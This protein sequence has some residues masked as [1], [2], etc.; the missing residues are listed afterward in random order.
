MRLIALAACFALFSQ[1]SGAAAEAPASGESTGP[2][3][4]GGA[5]N[6]LLRSESIGQTFSIDVSAP[7]VE[8]PLP[9]VYVLDGNGF[10][11]I[12]AQAAQLLQMGGELPPMIIVGVGYQVSSP[13]E[14]LALRVRDLTPTHSQAFV[15]RAAAQGNPLPEGIRPGGADV[16]L[17]FIDD[18]LKPFIAA[19][20]EVDPEDQTLVGDSLGGLF[21]LHVAF[22]STGSFDRYVAG[23]PSIWWDDAKLFRDES[24]LAEQVDDL[25]IRLF[26]SVGGLEEGSENEPF[27]MVSN[28]EK[29]EAA[30]RERSYSSLKLV[31]HVF[32][33][34][35]HL[36]VIPATISRGLRVVFAPSGLDAGRT[37]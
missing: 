35:T 5:Q 15:D 28:V 17:R 30:L 23:S 10:F 11:G 13:L 19:R 1:A 12:A 37:H 36:S 3:V 21:A 14:V 22:H 8:G 16:F 33:D 34:E 6:Y 7:P 9:V 2:A 20:Y 26:L 24:A 4:I 18:E 27:R 31:R 25:P 29:M 32:P